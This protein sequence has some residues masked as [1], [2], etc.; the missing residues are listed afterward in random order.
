MGAIYSSETSA[1]FERTPRRY[2]PEDS[3]LKMSSK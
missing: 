1:D 2:I 3:G